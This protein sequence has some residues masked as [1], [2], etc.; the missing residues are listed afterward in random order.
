M[1]QPGMPES[2]CSTTPHGD[3]RAQHELDNKPMLPAA[4]QPCK[5]CPWRKSNNKM[6]HPFNIYEGTEI[7]RLWRDISHQG[8]PSGCHLFDPAHQFN[9]QSAELGFV[10][11]VNVGQRRECSGSAALIQRE[12]RIAANYPNY[13]AY[14]AARPAGLKLKAFKILAKRLQGQALH[15]LTD[16]QVDQSLMNDPLEFVDEQSLFWQFPTETLWDLS[17]TIDV[18]SAGLGEQVECGCPVCEGHQSVHSTDDLT[19][20]GDA[21]VKVDR[22]LH[23]L[24]SAL[25]AFGIRTTDS[26]ID[27]R[28]AV[29]KLW[30]QRLPSLLA[31][32]PGGFNY[33]DILSEGAAFIRF[34]NSTPVEQEFIK[35]L[36]AAGF[37]TVS[38]GLLTQVMFS[39]HQIPAITRTARIR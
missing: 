36:H 3:M 29:E 10:K 20:A 22:E 12:L 7:Q 14:A 16:P 19:T 8:R 5:E 23:G 31:P 18:V 34:C 24:L 15:P 28:E 9:E 30:P 6:P 33:A 17:A 21:I 1:A 2:T 27:L 11:P 37:H 26:C 39:R 13:Q 38:M 32:A 35:R 25:T 4:A